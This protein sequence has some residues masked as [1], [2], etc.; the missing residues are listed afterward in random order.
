VEQGRRIQSLILKIGSAL[1]LVDK[2]KEEL[3]ILAALHD[4]GEIAIP[5][6]IL[7]K[8]GS[9]TP[10]EWEIMKRHPE[11]G[12]SI[13]RS[14]P[15]L[16]AIAEA[17]LSH[18]EHWDGTGYP[19]GLTGA[20]IPLISRILAVVDA[21]DAMTNGRPYMKAISHQEAA[22]E[23]K[24]CAGTHFDPELAGLFTKIVSTA[25]RRH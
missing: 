20:Q 2:E 6:N 11:I 23:I 5:E 10:V 13:A 19:R 18:H 15:D 16:V 22:E 1:G 25:V 17:I 3:A 4:I 21:Y 7:L 24:R 14:V 9:L 12:N 8:P